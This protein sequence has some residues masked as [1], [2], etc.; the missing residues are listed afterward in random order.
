MLTYNVIVPEGRLSA[1]QKSEGA[2]AITRTHHEV[3]AAPLY[4][5]QV[6]GGAGQHWLR[7][8][9]TSKKAMR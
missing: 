5:A 9:Y 2:A 3:T 8:R 4:F 6:P 1:D 7:E